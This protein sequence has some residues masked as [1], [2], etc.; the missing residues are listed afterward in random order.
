[1]LN[2]KLAFAVLAGCALLA[3]NGA[4]ADEHRRG[5]RG[6]GWHAHQH[7]HPHFRP[8]PVVVYR[9]VPVFYYAPA[10]V[11]LAPPPTALYAPPRPVIFGSL[12]LGDAR[13]RIGVTF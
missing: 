12:P 3:A 6:H 1:M 5:H 13:V 10:Q 8:R 7:A 9:P 2:R 11:Y 4:W